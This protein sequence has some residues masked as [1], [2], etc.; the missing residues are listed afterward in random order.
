MMWLTEPPPY[1]VGRAP[2]VRPVRIDP[3]GRAGPTRAQARG[4]RWR[5]TGQGFY[6]PA[7]VDATL[8]AQ[9]ILEASHDL[10]GSQ[11]VTG[12]AALHWHGAFWLDGFDAPGRPAPVKIAV[13]HGSRRPQLGVEVTS[14][15]IPPKE[16]QTVGGLQV[17]SPRCAVAFEMRY[18][19][20]PVAAV[21]AFDMAAAADLVSRAE[22][23]DYFEQLYHWTGIP[24]ARDAG[25]LVDENAWSPPEVD[26]RLVWPLELGHAP[27]LTN[28]PLFDRSGRHI[29]TPDLLD[30]NAGLVVEYE[31]ALHLAGVRRAKDLVREDA[32]RKVGLEYLT[33]VS[34][35][36]ADRSRMALRV[37]AALDR[38]PYLP[39][40]ECAWT[41]EPPPWWLP[42]HTVELRRALSPEQ[43]ERFLGYRRTA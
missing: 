32:F 31:G 25:L 26:A 34:A 24:G 15:F 4:P 37:A 8:P 9:R 30:L 13:V 28:R 29:G 6:V 43:R 19:P 18:A 17:V 10:R 20:T 35:D 38:S 39:R 23:L 11:S 42:T 21:R 16:R 2:L 14:E 5:R 40:E 41:I 27:P 12:W 36:R 33:L 22:L 1:D 7:D 3:L